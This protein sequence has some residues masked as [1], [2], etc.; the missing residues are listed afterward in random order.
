MQRTDCGAGRKRRGNLLGI[1]FRR[2]ASNRVFDG[3][4]TREQR[5][6]PAAKGGCAGICSEG[7]R[8][9]DPVF[10]WTDADGDTV[11]ERAEEFRPL[12]CRMDSQ[13]MSKSLTKIDFLFIM[14]VL[15]AFHADKSR[16]HIEKRRQDKKKKAPK[17]AA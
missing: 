4:R 10:G 9:D 3:Q 15:E 16:F 6:H 7:E 11:M 13:K 14:S 12:L 1:G 5:A 8:R 2:T 17:I